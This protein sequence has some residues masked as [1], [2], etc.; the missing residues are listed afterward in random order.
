MARR[1]DITISADR[2]V[3]FSDG[4]FAIA[5]TLLVLDL[6]ADTLGTVT[7]DADL[8]HALV[9]RS[10]TFF[11]FVVSFV[12]LCLL[13]TIHVW[14]FR[15]I[16]R[17]DVGLM[18]LN[19]ARLLFVVLVPFTTTVNA[20]YSQVALGRVLLPLN[21]FLAAFAAWLQWLWAARPSAG[22]LAPDLGPD[23][24]KAIGRGGLSAVVI[25]AA[26]VPVSVYLGSLAFVL[27]ALDGL[28]TRLLRGRKNVPRSVPD[29][30]AD[31]S[32]P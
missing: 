25:S 10:S 5:A 16:E 1:P 20:D 27:F 2:V 12:L 17:V 18:W 3:F 14:Q 9:S 4:V 19:A 29:P 31:P 23:G 13:W 11:S 7:S 21:F 30:P 26:I 22:L 24:V 8:W 28:L 6:T 15:W 32:A